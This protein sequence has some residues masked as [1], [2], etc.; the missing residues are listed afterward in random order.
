MLEKST[1]GVRV[2]KER[3]RQDQSLQFTGCLEEHV[4][5]SSMTACMGW[6]ASH[7]RC[8]NREWHSDYSITDCEGVC[9]R[10]LGTLGAGQRV[11]T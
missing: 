5:F 9:K 8:C 10:D 2:W 1:V 7:E 6:K 4:V 3:C 11:A